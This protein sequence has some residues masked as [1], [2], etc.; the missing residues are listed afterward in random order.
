MSVKAG[1]SGQKFDASVLEKVKD[2]TNRSFF[3]IEVDGGIDNETLL[4]AKK[5]GAS[6]FCANSYIFNSQHPEDQFRKLQSLLSS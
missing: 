6:I 4:D 2:M 5:V 1:E 3:S